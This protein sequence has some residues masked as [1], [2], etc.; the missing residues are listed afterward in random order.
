MSEK[1]DNGYI[2]LS[3]KGIR[4]EDNIFSQLEKVSNLISVK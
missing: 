1:V 2:D 3:G 4:D